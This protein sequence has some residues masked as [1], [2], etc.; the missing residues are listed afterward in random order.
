MLFK[1]VQTGV[2]AV[3]CYIIGDDSTKQA[4]VVDPGA[5]LEDIC[6]V[7]DKEKLNVRFI[8]LTHG[9]GD[10]IGAVEDLKKITGAK[11]AIHK[12]DA[13]MLKDPNLNHSEQI[14]GK[15]VSMDPDLILEDGQIISIGTLEVKVIHTPGHTKGGVCFLLGD[16]LITGDTLFRAS[17]GRTDLHGGN[18]DQLVKNIKQK[19]FILP[20]ETEVYP[21][22]GAAS[23]IAYEKKVNPYVR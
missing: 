22:H 2:Y 18:H 14:G 16:N 21:G 10:H 1:R 17:I 5:D 23:T 9:H 20:N 4:F 6:A 3:N 12:G 13:E 19:L 8:L 11:V 15:A 7:I